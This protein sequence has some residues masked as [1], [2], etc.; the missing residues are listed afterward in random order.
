MSDMQFQV[1]ECIGSTKL[2]TF[3]S[4]PLLRNICEVSLYISDLGSEMITDSPLL[5]DWNKAL[6]ITALDFMVPEAPKIAVCRF[7]LV[8]FGRHTSCPLCSPRIFPSAFEGVVSSRTSFM[9]F[10][11]IHPAVP[12]VPVLLI[13]NPLG[14][15][16]SPVNLSWNLTYR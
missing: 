8:S 16:T 6:R 11:L 15:R 7:S 12:Y 9:S 3:T 5:I 4:Y 2:K 13:V 1:S 14:S 10:S